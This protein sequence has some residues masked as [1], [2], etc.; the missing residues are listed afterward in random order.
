MVTDSDD[1]GIAK[2]LI[3]RPGAATAADEA[4]GEPRASAPRARLRCLDTSRLAQPDAPIVLEGAECIVGR[5]ERSTVRIDSLE[6]SRAHA[7]FYAGDGRWG[8]ED[9]GSTNGVRVN[10][11]KIEKQWLNPGDRVDLGRIPFVYELAGGERVPPP[12]A[13][14]PYEKTVLLGEQQKRPTAGGARLGAAPGAAGSSASAKTTAVRPEAERVGTGRG[15]KL[16]LAAVLAAAA[17]LAA[18]WLL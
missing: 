13:P 12:E 10:K 17:I 16:A 11:V 18:Y 1:D 3:L 6:I 15:R 9:L 5:G 7:R 8:V 14:G 4:G 2:T